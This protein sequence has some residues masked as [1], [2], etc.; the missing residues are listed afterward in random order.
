[1]DKR[2]QYYVYMHKNKINNKAY[3]GITKLPVQKRWQNGAGY[4]KQLKFHRAILKYG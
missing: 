1:M 3:I 4:C 2:G